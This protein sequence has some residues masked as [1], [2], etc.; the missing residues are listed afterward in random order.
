MKF[1]QGE[2]FCSIMLENKNYTEFSAVTAGA[3]ICRADKPYA[4]TVREY[5]LVHFVLSGRGVLETPRGRYE[6][7]AGEAFLVRPGEIASYGPDKNDPWEYT[8]IG[9]IGN[10]A[11]KFNGLDDVFEFDQTVADELDF[12]LEQNEGREEYMCSVLFKL[13]ASL[14]SS[15]ISRDYIKRIKSYINANYMQD[16]TISGIADMLNVSRKYLARIFREKTGITMKQYL[17]NK[18]MNEGKKLLSRGYTVEETA[19]MVGYSDSFVFSKAFKKQYGKPP[20][21]F[22]KNG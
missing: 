8:W 16:I 12:A 6:I 10:L 13:Y 20:V 14:F 18:R 11:E 5:Y 7:K 1:P 4:P 15:G 19:A 17:I 9:F 3:E 21:Y 22:K 2:F